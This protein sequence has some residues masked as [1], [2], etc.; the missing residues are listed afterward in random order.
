MSV[1][2]ENDIRSL[3]R[4]GAEIVLSESDVLTPSAKN[5]L[6][7]KKIPVRFENEAKPEKR[8]FQ[9]LFGATLSEKPE[10]MTHL[11][12]NML[13]FKD[14][15]RIIFR[16]KIDDLDAEILL[17]QVL[18]KKH[19]LLKLVDDL[20]EIL[21]FVRN[22]FRC[23]VLNEP[24]GEFSLLGMTAAQLREISHNPKKYFGKEHF[25]QHY[26]MGEVLLTLNKLRTLTRQTEL[27]AY[28]AFKDANGQVLREDIIMALNRLSSLFWIMMYQYEGQES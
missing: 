9:T 22:L 26:S 5:Y 17:A 16:G 1:L 25:L 21:A 23:D 28:Q 12:G 7:E 14:H 24:A 2:T 6:S 18:A 4:K 19:G 27:A 20:E 10:F 15:P 8:Q 13:V 3:C 11:Y